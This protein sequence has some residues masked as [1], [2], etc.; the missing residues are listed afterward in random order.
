MGSGDG[1][2]TLW[3]EAGPG[4]LETGSEGNCRAA[5]QMKAQ[6]AGSH[7]LKAADGCGRNTE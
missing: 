2:I 7:S 4:D 3:G 1:C 5:C 6:M